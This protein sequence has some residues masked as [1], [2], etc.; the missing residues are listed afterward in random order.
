MK[1][2]V[3]AGGTGS[4]LWPL[5]LATSKQ[6][7]PVYDK[8]MIYY[9]IS[10]LM[11]AGIREILIITTQQ[12]QQAFK[13]LLGDGSE[14]G[15]DFQYTIQPKPEGLAQALIL[16]EPFLDGHSCALILGDN[17]FYGTGLGEQL[18]KF[19]DID[20][21]SIFA[22]KVSNPEDYG[23]VT[24]DEQ[25]VALEIEEKPTKPKSNYAIPGLY[26][27]DKNAASYAKQIKPSERNELEISDLNEIYLRKGTLR[28]TILERGTAWLDTGTFKNLQNANNFVQL[29][30]DRQGLKIGCIEEIAWRKKFISHEKLL[31]L[32]KKY[33]KSIYGEYLGS[34]E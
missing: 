9:P 23:V 17:I 7:L 21:A 1:G 25:G 22:T 24:F 8:P 33:G 19:T 13:N 5:T 26:F 15:M 28:V 10:T 18:A 12:D 29:L 6:L 34:L 27:Y 4:R 3:L 31:Q 32:S 20:G 11:L 2:I 16:A 30:E 14:I